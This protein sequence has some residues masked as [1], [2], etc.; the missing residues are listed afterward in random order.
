MNQIQWTEILG[1]GPEQIHSLRS[2]GYCYLKQGAYDIAFSFFNALSILDPQNVYD[3]QTIGA[4][5]LQIGNPEK[6]LHSLTLAL[7]LDPAHFPTKLNRAKALFL[8]GYKTEGFV[9]ATEVT[10]APTQDLVNQALALLSA[11]KS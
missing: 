6:A 10:K 5:Y 2:V 9:Q 8:L 3:L 1:W 4:L 7:Q 11:Y